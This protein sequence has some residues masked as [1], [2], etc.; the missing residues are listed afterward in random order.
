MYQIPGRG[1]LLLIWEVIRSSWWQSDMVVMEGECPCHLLLLL[2]PSLC[3]L[4]GTVDMRFSRSGSKEKGVES[5]RSWRMGIKG[6]LVANGGES[7]WESASASEEKYRRKWEPAFV[8]HLLCASSSSMHE[9][10]THL[11][12]L[13]W[14]TRLCYYTG[15]ESGVQK[16][17]CAWV[18]TW[19]HIEAWL[20]DDSALNFNSVWLENSWASPPSSCLS[21]LLRDAPLD[22]NSGNIISEPVH[23][24]GIP[25]HPNNAVTTA[26]CHRRDCWPDQCTV[27]LE[28]VLGGSWG[29]SSASHCILCVVNMW[30]VIS[31]LLALSKYWNIANEISLTFQKLLTWWRHLRSGNSSF[32]D[33]WLENRD[34]K[35]WERTNFPLSGLVGFPSIYEAQDRPNRGLGT[36][37][38][39]T[40]NCQSS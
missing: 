23:V 6:S 14:W 32:D 8:G 35:L 1:P 25:G 33:L 4:C 21:K 20:P 39:N 28:Q 29:V 9:Y 30:G 15:K 37:C 38:L 22:M 3:W 19:V 12:H 2:L 24:D 34:D 31:C 26:A 36:I 27:V 5:K 18:R 40:S 7:R 11:S 13:T 16:G 10:I 17:E